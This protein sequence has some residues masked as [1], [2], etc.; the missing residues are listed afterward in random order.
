MAPDFCAHVLCALN[1][2]CCCAAEWKADDT[3]DLV[4]QSGPAVPLLRGAFG[5]VPNATSYDFEAQVKSRSLAQLTV[6]ASFAR[7]ADDVL[8]LTVLD[9]DARQDV[10]FHVVLDKT[11]EK[12]A[13]LSSLWRRVSSLRSL[14]LTPFFPLSL[15]S[16]SSSSFV[17]VQRGHWRQVEQ[18]LD[19]GAV[20]RRAARRLG[21]RH[22]RASTKRVRR[23]RCDHERSLNRSKR[24][25]Q[26]PKIKDVFCL[27]R[28]P[29]CVCIMGGVYKLWC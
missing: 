26:K 27:L 20:C 16:S 5:R 15:L 10:Y 25:N 19:A 3:I 1:S 13:L 18:P 17:G 21:A 8:Y 6:D 12:C 23:Q 29:F 24:K 22:A 7:A 2:C 11:G 14:S 28:C 4:V 9:L